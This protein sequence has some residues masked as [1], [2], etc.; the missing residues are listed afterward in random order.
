MTQ[1]HPE[2][3]A[4]SIVLERLY[5]M[6]LNA[7]HSASNITSQLKAVA[8]RYQSVT[9][10]DIE[11]LPW[12]GWNGSLDPTRVIFVEPPNASTVAALWYTW[13]FSADKTIQMCRFYYGMWKMSDPHPKPPVGTVKRVPMFIGFRF[14]PPELQGNRHSYYHSQPC[15]SMGSKDTADRFAPDVD[16]K[17]PT[18]P[19]AAT[20]AVDLVLCVYLALYGASRFKQFSTDLQGENRVRRNKVLMM[21]L[22]RVTALAKRP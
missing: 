16:D 1:P 4:I 5:G 19:I 6:S 22:S 20:N 21:A 7:R 18:L 2:Q 15:R 11:N 8:Q 10:M 12:S 13:S 9:S 14:E 3:L 17:E